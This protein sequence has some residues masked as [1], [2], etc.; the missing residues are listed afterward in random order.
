MNPNDPVN[1]ENAA[2][3]REETVA[4]L[5]EIEPDFRIT[6]WVARSGHWQARISIDGLRNAG[7]HSDAAG[8]PVLCRFLGCR[9]GGVNHVHGGRRP[10]SAKARSR[11]RWS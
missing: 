3:D 6:E 5:L 8:L 7:L 9:R 11:G 1:Q 10:R 2:L 4:Q